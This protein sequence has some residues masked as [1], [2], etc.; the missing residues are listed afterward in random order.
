MKLLLEMAFLACQG[1]HR[2]GFRRS[3]G[4]PATTLQGRS[5]KRLKTARFALVE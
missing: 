2:T 5:L 1:R 4:V 3:P